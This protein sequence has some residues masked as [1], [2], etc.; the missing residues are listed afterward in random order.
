M[1]RQTSAFAKSVTSY[2]TDTCLV[3]GT[4]HPFDLRLNEEKMRTETCPLEDQLPDP[5]LSVPLGP[6]WPPWTTWP[7]PDSSGF[8]PSLE[9]LINW[10]GASHRGFQQ[11]TTLSFCSVCKKWKVPMTKTFS[12]FSSAFL[13]T[14]QRS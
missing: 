2:S 4:S 6:V 7:W 1:R 12:Y 8:S 11:I 5:V 10:G 3:L 9:K 14:L 13:E